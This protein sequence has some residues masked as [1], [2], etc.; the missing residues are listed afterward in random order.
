[1]G[2]RKLFRVSY[3]RF[4]YNMDAERLERTLAEDIADAVEAENPTR[5]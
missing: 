3:S 1:M 2:K 5:C 4:G